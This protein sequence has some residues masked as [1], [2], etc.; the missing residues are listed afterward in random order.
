MHLGGYPLDMAVVWTLV[1]TIELGVNRD[2]FKSDTKL[3]VQRN[4]KS[5]RN[6]LKLTETGFF[7]FPFEK[8][9]SEYNHF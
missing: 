2:S 9:I 3:C 7:L 8:W 1:A 6:N 5:K 4:N